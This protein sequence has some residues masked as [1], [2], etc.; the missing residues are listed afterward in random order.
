MQATQSFLRP[1]PTVRW[2]AAAGLFRTDR[3]LI[4][5]YVL[6]ASQGG[7]FLEH[8][9]Q[10]TQI[11]LLGVPGPQ[12]RGVVGALDLEWVHIIWNSAVLVATAALVAV[13]RRNPW[14][15][16][17]LLFALWHELEH[18]YI[19][20]AFL[21]TGVVGTPGLLATGGAFRGGLPLRRPD[22]HF[23]YNLVETSALL[24]A[25]FYQLRAAARGSHRPIQATA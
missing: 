18:L 1:Q 9:A 22:L 17:T 2:K 4:L 24:L 14:L 5:F 21:A 23:L 19:M 6:A 25:F 16:A 13:Y 11:H 12:A 8:V 7:H 15:W 10:V 20:R 3:W